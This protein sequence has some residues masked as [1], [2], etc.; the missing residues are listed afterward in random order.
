[1]LIAWYVIDIMVFL[2]TFYSPAG[3]Q[4]PPLGCPKIVLDHVRVYIIHIYICIY[5]R[6][7]LPH[8]WLYT[9]L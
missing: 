9:A 7:G 2:V 1:M 6:F 5:V 8:Y 3:G 4:S